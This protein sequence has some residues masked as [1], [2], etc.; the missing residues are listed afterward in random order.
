[1]KDEKYFAMVLPLSLCSSRTVPLE[2][3]HFFY[4]FE[5]PTHEEFPAVYCLLHL[6]PGLFRRRHIPRPGPQPDRGRHDQPPRVLRYGVQHADGRQYRYPDFPE[7]FV[8]HEA[9]N[10]LPAEYMQILLQSQRPVSR[11]KYFVSLLFFH[12][13]PAYM[14]TDAAFEAVI[15]VLRTN[16]LITIKGLTPKK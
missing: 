10:K 7:H 4:V 3:Y 8:Y 1:V 16:K 13:P 12:L 5:F 11:P 14:C 9:S 6:P 15:V 2:P